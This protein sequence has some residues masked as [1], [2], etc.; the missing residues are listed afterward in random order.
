MIGVLNTDSYFMSMLMACIFIN[1]FWGFLNLLLLR[2]NPS[3]HFTKILM[4]AAKLI[5]SKL[6]H[7]HEVKKQQQSPRIR[8]IR[9]IFLFVFYILYNVKNTQNRQGI[10]GNQEGGKRKKELDK[11]CCVSSLR[12]LCVEGLWSFQCGST[13]AL[14]FAECLCCTVV[15]WLSD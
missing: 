15:S 13:E 2:R 6:E 12:L 11:S 4:C 5:N 1:L 14:S 3:Y 9:L 7:N 10:T 8:V